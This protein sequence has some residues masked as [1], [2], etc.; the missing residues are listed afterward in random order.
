MRCLLFVALLFGCHH[1]EPAPAP[2]KT[3]QHENK[4]PKRARETLLYVD[5]AVRASLTSGELP[6]ERLPLCDLLARVD[7]PCA[8]VHGLHLYRESGAVEAGDARALTL[9]LDDAGRAL[10]GG[11]P[12]TD[13][14]VYV[15]KAV[16]PLP[17]K[18]I[19]Y[20]EEPVRGGTR[21]NLDGKLVSRMKRNQLDD[22]LTPISGDGDDAR[23]SLGDFLAP[24]HAAAPRA[25][26]LV[27]PDEGVV[28]V[29]DGEVG[30]VSFS[31]ERQR[32]GQMSFHFGARTVP[33]VAVNVYLKSAPPERTA[34]PTAARPTTR[35]AGFSMG[36]DVALGGAAGQ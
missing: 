12:V 26:E 35:R 34:P 5:G 33:A 20:L 22:T 1:Q 18:G 15:D 28:R 25:I 14:T 10:V 16:P 11:A 3:T 32:H 27:T 23:Y 4:T 8:A 21:V 7:A 31:A 17:V 13:V 2:I 9:E 24:L 29:P 30:R 36:C 6:A 19:P